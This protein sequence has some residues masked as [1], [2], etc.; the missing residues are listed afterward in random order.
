[1]GL[2]VDPIEMPLTIYQGATFRKSFA[3]KSGPTAA[4]ATPVDLTGCA[5]RAHV[6]EKIDSATA[7]LEMT[8]ENGRI[9]LGGAAGTVAL[10]VS[11]ETTAALP[12]L[13]RAAR[14]DLEI[15]WPD[16]EVTRLF[17]GPVTIGPEVTR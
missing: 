7:L 9:A 16:G 17:Q 5:A 11:D 8:T 2:L 4:T 6:R 3:W 13:K 1:M 10:E 14:W 12:R 15:V